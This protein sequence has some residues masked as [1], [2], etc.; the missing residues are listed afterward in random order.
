MLVLMPI[1]GEP[2]DATMRA[3]RNL[4]GHVASIHDCTSLVAAR[5]L[6]ASIF[7]RSGDQRALWVDSD[8]VFEVPHAETLMYLARASDSDILSAHYVKKQSGEDV[9]VPVPG[10]SPDPY[11]IQDCLAVGFGFCVTHRRVFEKMPAQE[12]ECSGGQGAMWFQHEVLNGQFLFEDAA[13]CVRA[14]DAGF[15][16]QVA[17]TVQVGHAGLTVRWPEK[18][19]SAWR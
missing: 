2:H 6:L 7:L 19:V 13:F 8:M 17:T 10:S 14:S 5:G 1:R 12:F 16:V 4:G 3:A 11:G 15:R 9:H 18:Q